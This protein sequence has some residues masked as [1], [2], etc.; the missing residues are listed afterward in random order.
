MFRNPICMI[1]PILRHLTFATLIFILFADMACRKK[2]KIDTNPDYQL[3]FSTDTLFFDTVFTT[4]GSV[5]QRLIVHNDNP[6][7][8]SISSIRLAGGEASFYGLNINGMAAPTAE[9]V[10]I[11]GG[12]SIFIFVRLTIDPNNQ[13]IPFIVSDSILFFT[14]GSLQQVQLAA[15]GQNARFYKNTSLKGNIVWDS[16]IAH[17]IY[18]S[19]A[20]DTA[21]TLTIMPGAHVYFHLKSYL[22][23]S[24]EASLMVYGTLEHPVFFLG[25]RLDPFYRDLPGQWDGIY[26]DQGSKN[27]QIN[28]AVIK[29][30]TTGIIVDSVF[31]SAEPSLKIDN[32]IIQNMT[33]DGILAFSANILSTNC[34]IGNCG[35]AALYAYAGGSY[36]FRQLT[37]GNYWSG[38]VRTSPSLVL[39][40]YSYDSLGNKKPSA[41]NKAYFGNS[42]I[43]GTDP[44]EI[45]RDSVAEVPFEYTFDH[46]LLRTTS[47]ITNPLRYIECIA[48]QDPRFIDPQK[49]NFEIDSISP[50]IGKGIPMGVPFDLK[51]NDR[52]ATPDLGAF[53]YV[54]QR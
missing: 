8:V 42:I 35:G 51:G 12:D 48:N 17:V 44:D 47:A 2:D 11:P 43:Y 4:V 38:S 3:W 49:F 14:N 45:L 13:S 39:S 28:Y 19:L 36:D 41:L 54:K 15:W 18:G 33:G 24:K 27:N 53:Q 52:G 29:N 6:G 46:S 31:V 9:N 32:T 34:V 5:T 40:N 10:E 50:A 37:V 30:G 26:L 21:S 22:S 7:K 20:V 16:L 25:D 1:R 23:I